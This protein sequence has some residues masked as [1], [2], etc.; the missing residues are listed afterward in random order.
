MALSQ[1]IVGFILVAHLSA[2]RNLAI[3]LVAPLKDLNKLI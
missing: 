2:A 3:I 1:K